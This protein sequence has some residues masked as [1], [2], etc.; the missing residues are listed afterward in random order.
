M[1]SLLERRYLYKI[2][3]VKI[4]PLLKLCCSCQLLCFTLSQPE[5]PLLRISNQNQVVFQHRTPSNHNLLWIVVTLLPPAFIPSNPRSNPENKKVEK[6]VVTVSWLIRTY[7]K[8]DV[9]AYCITSDKSPFPINNS[10]FPTNAF[11]FHKFCFLVFIALRVPTF[12]R[13]CTLPP[14]HIHYNYI[15]SQFTSVKGSKRI[16]HRTLTQYEISF[17][18]LHRRCCRQHRR[19]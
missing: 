11:C 6:T 18:R 17:P 19:C 5:W 7:I 3:F 9:R 4:L 15:G 8:Y 1:K 16:L 13:W 14:P 2:C 12:Q 10:L